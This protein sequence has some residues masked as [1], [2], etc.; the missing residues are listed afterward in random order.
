MR[1]TFL[2]IDSTV[3]SLLY[4]I[5]II[6]GL[7]IL[8]YI[9]KAAVKNAILETRNAS[10]PERRVTNLEKIPNSQQIALQKK[11]DNGEI[12]F[13]EYKKEWDRLS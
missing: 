2:V 9:I 6:I 10:E 1:F 5:G 4:I 11:Y 12:T 8:Y 13:E 3:L 7:L